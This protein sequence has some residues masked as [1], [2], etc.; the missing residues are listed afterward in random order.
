M[1]LGVLVRDQS[2]DELCVHTIGLAPQPD[3]LGIVAGVLGIEHKDDE[4]ELV[5]SIS[6]QLVVGAGGFHA[7]AAAGRQPLEKGQ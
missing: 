6:Q 7:D 3:G 5:G 4:A 1:Q 2:S